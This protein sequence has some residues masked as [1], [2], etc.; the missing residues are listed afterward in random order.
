MIAGE[1]KRLGAH[2]DTLVHCGSEME[3]VRGALVWAEDGDQLVL[4]THE[5]R[6]SVIALLERLA[7]AGWRA[8]NPLADVG[9]TT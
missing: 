5:G 7:D 4:T 1:L 6:E 9:A 3:A 2:T 8:G